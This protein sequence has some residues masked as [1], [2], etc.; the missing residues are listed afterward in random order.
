MRIALIGGTFDPVHLGHLIGAECTAESLHLD[1]VLFVPAATPPH[2]FTRRISDSGHRV[3]MLRLAITGNPRFDL[4][5]DEIE[6]GGASFTVDT[7]STVHARLAA[8]DDLYLVVGA[9][10]LVDFDTWKDWRRIVATCRIAG[11]ERPGTERARQVVER[12][13]PDLRVEW[14]RMPLIDISSTH[15]RSLSAQGG[16]IRYLVPEPV[17]R[18]IQEN[19]LYRDC[20]G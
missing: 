14:V 19:D 3:N 16:S 6:R 5:L 2:K 20:R 4:L 9:D 11:L 7:V 12:K 18:Y 1:R 8:G 17:A 10:N 15:V 13:M